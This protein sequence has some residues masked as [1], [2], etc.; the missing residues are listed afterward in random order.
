MRLLLIVVAA[1]AAL[2]G[3]AS[4]PALGAEDA[5]SRTVVVSGLSSP[6]DVVATRSEPRRLYVVEQRGTIRVLDRGKLRKGFFLDVRKLVAFGGEQGLLGLAFDPK[7]ATNRFAYVD[8]TDVNGDTRV[9]RY[10]TNASRAIPSSARVLLR[11]DQPYANHNGGDLVFGPDGGL[12]VGMGDGG[13][14]GDPENR[15]QNMQALLG[16]MLR[17]D[18]RRPGS[19]PTIVALG[20]RNPWR[21]SFDRQTGDLYIGDVGQ[22]EVEEID[23]TPK[24][25]TGLLNYGW[26]VYEGSHPYEDKAPGPGKLVFPV[27]QYTHD[28]GGCTVVGGFVYRGKARPAERGRYI[29]GDYC[30][31][32]ITSLRIAGGKATAVRVEPF[33]IPN[34]SSFGEDVAGELYATSLDGVLY[35][36]S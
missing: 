30:S 14:G 36:L 13:S 24:S 8:Y 6:D 31:G 5:F 9:V 27:Y 4:R 10:K 17:L 26:D 2:L 3:T 35:R 29:F 16:K 33:T 18:V 34:L 20:L 1:A 25:E 22:G 7:Y 15:A 28:S 19:A 21:Y 32:V 11:I 23:Y 12:Y